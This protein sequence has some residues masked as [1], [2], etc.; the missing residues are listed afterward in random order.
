MVGRISIWNLVCYCISTCK[1]MAAVAS[2]GKSTAATGICPFRIWS[3]L[4]AFL[5]FQS[6]LRRPQGI[7]YTSLITFLPLLNYDKLEMLIYIYINK[8]MRD[9]LY[10]NFPDQTHWI[11]C[12]KSLRLISMRLN[13]LLTS[14]TA[15]CCHFWF[16]A[17]FCGFF[18]WWGWKEEWPPSP[19]S[20]KVS[21]VLSV[22]G[23]W[24]LHGSFLSPQW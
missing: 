14:V 19:T 8:T 2:Q 24:V 17:S 22:W 23:R 12:G 21:N 1:D 3:C 13:P 6:S 15:G 4:L 7:I 18:P 5:S 10:L 11:A 20:S 9:I 16:K